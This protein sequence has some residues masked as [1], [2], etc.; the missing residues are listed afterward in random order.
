MGFLAGRTIVI[1][2]HQP[3]DCSLDVDPE[4]IC[5]GDRVEND[6][7]RIAQMGIDRVLRDS[8]V[9]DKLHGLSD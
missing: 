7:G 2:G 6:I 8:R 1:G 9:A 3:I 5:I 4:I